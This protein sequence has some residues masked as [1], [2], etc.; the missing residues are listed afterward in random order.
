MGELRPD[1]PVKDK[2]YICVGGKRRP[3]PCISS[4]RLEAKFPALV[5]APDMRLCLERMNFNDRHTVGKACCLIGKCYR[6]V[7]DVKGK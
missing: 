3:G 2:N 1:I 4:S 5:K 6:G 7:V